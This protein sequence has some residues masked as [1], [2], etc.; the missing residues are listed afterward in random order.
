[1]SARLTDRVETG[2]ELAAAA[3]FGGAVAYAALVWLS[4]LVPQ[5]WPYSLAAGILAA[6]LCFRTMRALAGR[7]P[8]PAVSIFNV[9]D[10]E[11]ELDEL[12]LTE[13]DR[14]GCAE[15]VLTDADVIKGDELLLTD[16]VRAARPV[17]NPLML[18]DILAELGPDSRVVRLF[19]PKAMPTPAELKTRIDHHL[20][21]GPPPVPLSDASQALSDALAE[22]RRS[23]R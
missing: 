2:V 19:D 22:L 14:T 21:R 5:A 7:K 10:I 9:R 16:E 8:R 20:G 11:L 18:D 12:L 1:M 15:L 6:L 13:S 3:M 17:A 23:L 4:A